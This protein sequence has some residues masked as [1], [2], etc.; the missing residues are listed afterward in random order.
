[1]HT[2]NSNFKILWAKRSNLASKQGKIIEGWPVF[3]QALLNS[4]YHKR[5]LSST[6]G[7]CM[8]I[9]ALNQLKK[10]TIDLSH[11]TDILSKEILKALFMHG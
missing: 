10:N 8:V 7:F 11:A 9:E 5:E 1:M 6:R 2:M 4:L 3:V